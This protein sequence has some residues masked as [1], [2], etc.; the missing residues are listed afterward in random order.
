M[1]HTNQWLYTFPITFQS[2]NDTFQSE[3]FVTFEEP[4][5]F[6]DPWNSLFLK[7]IATITWLVGFIGSCFIYTFVLYEVQGYAATYRTVINQL[8]TWC[9]I[10]VSSVIYFEKVSL[11]QY[12]F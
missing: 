7:I 1:N 11:I 2:Q 5:L 12:N 6:V 9:Y 4:N 3:I 8:V 10:V